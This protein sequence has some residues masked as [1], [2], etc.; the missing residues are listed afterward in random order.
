MFHIP[1]LS[2]NLWMSNEASTKSAQRR[3]QFTSLT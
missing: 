1:Q 3:V 2:D